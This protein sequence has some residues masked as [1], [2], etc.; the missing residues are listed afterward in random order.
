MLLLLRQIQKCPVVL[1]KST[2]E[3]K[4]SVFMPSLDLG[5]CILSVCVCECECSEHSLYILH[6]NTQNHAHTHRSHTHTQKFK[7][8]GYSSTIFS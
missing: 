3:N 7:T 4:M 5:I 2:R 8:P 1:E 6:T